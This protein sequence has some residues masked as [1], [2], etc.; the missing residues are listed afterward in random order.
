MGDR[1]ETISK[2]PI[3]SYSDL[4]VW[5]NG[6][7]IVKIVYSAKE[8]KFLDEYKYNKIIELCSNTG[9]MLKKLQNSLKPKLS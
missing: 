8:L 5:R 2:I 4:R 6:I 3:K 7:E 1:E 9:K